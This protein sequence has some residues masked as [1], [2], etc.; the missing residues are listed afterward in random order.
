MEQLTAA[1]RSKALNAFGNS[2][3][4]IFGSNPAR[5]MTARFSYA[6]LLSHAGSGLAAGL[7]PIRA[8]L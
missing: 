3:S 5:H 2:D 4:G 1:A 7:I 8:A 6:F